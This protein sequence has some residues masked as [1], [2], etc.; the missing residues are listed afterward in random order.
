MSRTVHCRKYKKDLPGLDRAPFPGAEGENIFNSVSKQAW[1][2]WLQ[3]Q[4]MLINE[5]QLNLLDP[6]S[7]SFLD[8]Q[9]EK[10]FDN[11]DFERPKGY[12]PPSKK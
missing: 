4:T 10:F 3:H 6:D 9:R 1:Q 12:V 11:D 7:K 5:N 8:T 2:E